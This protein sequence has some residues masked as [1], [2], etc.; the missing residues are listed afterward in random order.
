MGKEYLLGL[1]VGSTTA[2]TGW[3]RNKDMESSPGLTEELTK[4]NG[5]MASKMAGALIVIN[6]ESNAKDY[7]PMVRR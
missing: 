4:V 1:T 3:I 7:G 5:R 2:N 6:K